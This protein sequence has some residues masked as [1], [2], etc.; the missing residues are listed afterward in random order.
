MM[1]EVLRG[2]PMNGDFQAPSSFMIYKEGIFSEN[3]LIDA[4]ANAKAKSGKTT[5]VSDDFELNS[6]A[7][8]KSI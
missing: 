5:Q 7:Q 6:F 4:H 8:T 1:K 3:G 2:G